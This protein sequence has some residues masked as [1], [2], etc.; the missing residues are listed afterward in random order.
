[1]VS[2]TIGPILKTKLVDLSVEHFQQ[3]LSR[4]GLVAWIKSNRAG[5]IPIMG[6]LLKSIKLCD[7]ISSAQTNNLPLEY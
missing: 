3:N 1:M 5:E 6:S 4:S 7:R 2:D